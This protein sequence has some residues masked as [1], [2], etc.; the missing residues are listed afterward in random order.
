LHGLYQIA[1]LPAS[2]GAQFTAAAAA[3]SSSAAAAVLQFSTTAGSRAVT[4]TFDGAAFYSFTDG[5]AL[6]V[7]FQV[8]VGGL[9]I[10]PGTYT[11]AGGGAS[12]SFQVAGIATSTASA[13]ENDGATS[14]AYLLQTQQE[15]AVG[16]FGAGPFG[17]GG[18]GSSNTYTSTLL[19]QW[20][21]ANW[22]ENRIACPTNGA[23]ISGRR[24]SARRSRPAT[25][26]RR[27]SRSPTRPRRTP[28]PSWPCRSSRSWPMAAP[29]R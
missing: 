27:P 10:A 20:T 19:R 15:G 25:R 14:V 3:G 26:L 6:V 21:M 29:I 13:F 4:V 16:G 12:A 22:G 28:A 11:L 9:T 7:W 17:Q 1:A 24:R 18:F 2:G 8:T 5:Q 23:S